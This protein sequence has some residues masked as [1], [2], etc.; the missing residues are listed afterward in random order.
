MDRLAEHEA[1]LR[2]IFDAPDDDLPRLVY[3]DFLDENGDPLRAEFIRVQCRLAALPA[4]PEPPEVRALR[5]RERELLDALHPE[6]RLINWTWEERARIVID[7][8]FVT[9]PTAMI[10]PGELDDVNGFRAK[11]VRSR[12]HWFGVKSLAIQPGWFLQAE[13]VA[14]LFELPALQRVT[15]WD[16]GGHVEEVAG[17]P[18]TE[19]GGAYALIDMHEQ[20][21]ITLAGVEALAQHRGARRIT[22]LD[23]TYNRLENDAA[24]TLVRSPYLINLRRLDV[25]ENR[26]SGEMWAQ[27]RER[28]GADVVG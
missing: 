3:A 12:P 21:V 24:R 6:L 5:L 7:R 14:T 26:F 17:G 8:G 18:Q 2:A 9:Q 10:C 11:V 25:A 19:D 20:P 23:L 28:F 1:F 15:E 27:L 22:D 13:H 4:Q 16:L